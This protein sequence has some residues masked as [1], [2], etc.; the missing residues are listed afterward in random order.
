MNVITIS[1]IFLSMLW[2]KIDRNSFRKVFTLTFVIIIIIIVIVII[3]WFQFSLIQCL[4]STWIVIANYINSNYDLNDLWISAELLEC[5]LLTRFPNSLNNILCYLWI[6][7][8]QIIFRKKSRVKILHK[9][10]NN[11]DIEF[12]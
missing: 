10:P 3:S 6:T 5:L 11:L 7:T 12:L 8:N 2:A 1:Y 4:I 9:Q